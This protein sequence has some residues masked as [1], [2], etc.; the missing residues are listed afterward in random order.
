M[1]CRCQKSSSIFDNDTANRPPVAVSDTGT[2]SE[3]S[4]LSVDATSGLLANDSD[5]D[6]DTLVISSVAGNS[7]NVGSAAFGSAGGT[8]TIES[9]GAYTFNPGTDFDYLAR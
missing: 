3:N 5:Q 9:N 1:L 4:N 6:G 8:F 2:T 7:S